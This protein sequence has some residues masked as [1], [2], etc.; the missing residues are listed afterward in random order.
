VSF[1]TTVSQMQGRKLGYVLPTRAVVVISVANRLLF[2][3]LRFDEI[4]MMDVNTPS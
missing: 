1:T 3:V 4:S 2:G